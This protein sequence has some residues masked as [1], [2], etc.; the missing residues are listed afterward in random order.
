MTRKEILD[1]VVWGILGFF[2][3][4]ILTLVSLM[5]PLGG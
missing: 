1:P 5:I 4:H 3:G 2:L